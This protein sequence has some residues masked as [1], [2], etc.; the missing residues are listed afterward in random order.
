M[1]AIRQQFVVPIMPKQTHINP[2]YPW[3]NDYFNTLYSR[4]YQHA[5]SRGYI[6]TLE[7]F[8]NNI[9][10]FL[11]SLSILTPYEGQYSVIPLPYVEQILRT[12]NTVLAEDVVV[13]PIPYYETSNTAGGYT[14]IIG[15]E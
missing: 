7:D 4:L 1:E 3:E 2:I 10:D 12:K 11:N 6:G 15:G 5:L 8:K 13:D 14:V 9:G